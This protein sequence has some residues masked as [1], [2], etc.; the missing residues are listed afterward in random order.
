MQCE[1][2]WITIS[3]RYI[4]R[5]K[6]DKKVFDDI[7]FDYITLPDHYMYDMRFALDLRL[8]HNTSRL[9]MDDV[10]HQDIVGQH[11]E[12]FD[13]CI[14]ELVWEDDELAVEYAHLM[15]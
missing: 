5:S 1:E 7:E 14:K 4:S 11:I 9:C 3:N 13:E 2:D 12:R 10:P 8:N 6:W 15:I